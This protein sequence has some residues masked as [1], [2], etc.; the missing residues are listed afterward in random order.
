VTSRKTPADRECDESPDAPAR[1]ESLLGRVLRVS[2]DEL[3]RR[4]AEYKKE[5]EE[6]KDQASKRPTPNMHP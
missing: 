3:K 4:E 5:R 2:K 1:F 6:K